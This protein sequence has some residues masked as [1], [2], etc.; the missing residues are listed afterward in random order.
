MEQIDRLANKKDQLLRENE[1]LR[2]ENKNSRKFLFTNSQNSQMPPLAS[3]SISDGS[4]LG[5]GSSSSATRYMVNKSINS[6]SN[7][8]NILNHAISK[9][10]ENQKFIGGGE[11]E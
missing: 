3:Q 9:M 11:E 5:S 7:G 6:G 10:K 4:K 8:S 2:N 1:K